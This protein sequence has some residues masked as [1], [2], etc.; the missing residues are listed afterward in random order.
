LR[1]GFGVFG[2]GFALGQIITDATQNG[3]S[4]G[5]ASLT[6]LMILRY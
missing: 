6:F 4:C 3:R 5:G 2:F 1:F